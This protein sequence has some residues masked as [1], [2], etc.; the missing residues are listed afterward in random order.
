MATRIRRIGRMAVIERTL[1]GF[2]IRSSVPSS[3]SS[4]RWFDRISVTNVEEK[5]KQADLCR[6]KGLVRHDYAPQ[7]DVDIPF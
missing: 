2:D 4:L 3:F 5:A 7:Q 1:S 6:V